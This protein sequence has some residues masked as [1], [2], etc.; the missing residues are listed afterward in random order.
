MDA[1][2]KTRGFEKVSWKQ[3]EK[4]Y[5]PN[6]MESDVE[7][8][9]NLPVR[10]TA[11]SAGY[12]I[13]STVDVYLNPNGEVTMPLGWKVYML[14]H[15]ALFIMPRS[16][17]GFKHYVRLANTVGLIDSDYYN[18]EKNEGHCWIKLRNEGYDTLAIKKG[19]AIAQC[20]FV[21]FLLAD[22]DGFNNGNIRK[23]GFGHTDNSG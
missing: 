12:D 19:D 11:L 23:G 5:R 18:N 10:A 8:N 16:G 7:W 3:W 4:D 1:F 15:E 22:G 9:V 2:N 6:D 13:F 14:P 17:M 21:P 20:V